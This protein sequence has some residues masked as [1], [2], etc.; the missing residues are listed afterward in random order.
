MLITLRRNPIKV[1]D[2]TKLGGSQPQLSSVGEINQSISLVASLYQ[3]LTKHYEPTLSSII[4]VEEVPVLLL[5][6]VLP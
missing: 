2:K 3:R 5:I 1:N 6:P 4:N